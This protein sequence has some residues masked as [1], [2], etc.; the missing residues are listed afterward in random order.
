MAKVTFAP[1]LI[2]VTDK[3]LDFVE[4]LGEVSPGNLKFV[5]PYSGGSEA[6]E[7][8][9]KFALPSVRLAPCMKE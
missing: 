8:A 5:K 2:S 4:R 7:S 1:P 3:L 9:L 6:V